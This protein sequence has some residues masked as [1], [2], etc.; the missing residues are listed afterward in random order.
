VERIVL[1][2]QELLLADLSVAVPDMSV[3]EEVVEGLEVEMKEKTVVPM[4]IVILGTAVQ[5]YVVQIPAEAAAVYVYLALQADLL[6]LRLLMIQGGLSLEGL[7]QV[8][9]QALP[10]GFRLLL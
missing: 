6:L 8:R 1:A 10:Q 2:L 9:L 4:M 3:M 7:R 5:G